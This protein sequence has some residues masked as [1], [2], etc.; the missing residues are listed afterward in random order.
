MASAV[1]DHLSAKTKAAITP[2]LVEDGVV[3]AA[4]MVLKRHGIAVDA[5]V[6]ARIRESL[7]ALR[8]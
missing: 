7:A 4:V 5:T 8:D 3:G 6:F 1:V 2:V